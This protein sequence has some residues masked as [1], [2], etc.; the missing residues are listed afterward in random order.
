MVIQ[1]EA[2]PHK[3]SALY[4]GLQYDMSNELMVAESSSYTI[5]PSLYAMRGM[6]T[7]TTTRA[8]WNYLS[9]TLSEVESIGKEI[10]KGKYSYTI[11]T[12]AKGNEESFKALSGKQT[13]IL[14]IATHGFFLTPD[15]TA[16]QPF[17]AMR[18]GGD[19][20]HSYKVDPMERAGLML[21]GGNR[22]WK[23]DTIPTGI[24][25]GILT[26]KEI[27]QLD[28]RGTDLVVLSACQTGLGEVSGEGVFGLQRAFKQA[29]CKTL[30]MSLWNVSDEATNLM[31]TTFYQEL[32]KGKNKRE[33][34]LLAQ[35]SCRQKF[36]EPYYWAAFVMLD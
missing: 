18:M 24:E 15:E 29:G 2:L 6:V 22:A 13:G 7:D 3:T 28:L 23:R 4:G 11:Y 30:I 25:D 17:Y 21:S 10:K 26:A 31:M 32:L 33:A 20:M 8:G 1:D 14:H 16:T 34:F 35:N 9:G 5:K 36:K 27:S 19:E 12:G